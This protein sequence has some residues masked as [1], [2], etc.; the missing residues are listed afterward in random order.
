[1]PASYGFA[2]QLPQHKVWCTGHQYQRGIAGEQVGLGCQEDP[3]CVM[4]WSGMRTPTLRRVRDFPVARS[5]HCLGNCLLARKMS[6][7]CTAH[8]QRLMTLSPERAA[9]HVPTA[10]LQPCRGKEGPDPLV[11][12][13]L[14]VLKTA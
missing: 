13:I 2:I 7:N 14:R 3:A 11:A 1:M 12:N 5:T 4:A 9:W 8:R 10:L 6:V